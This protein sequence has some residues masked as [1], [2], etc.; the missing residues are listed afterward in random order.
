MW[1]KKRYLLR[2]RTGQ[3]TAVLARDGTRLAIQ[4]D[5]GPLHEVDAVLANRGRALSLRIGERMHLIH[6]S[7][8]DGPGGVT[9]TLQGRPVELT[10]L[11]ELRALAL[12]AEG[13]G[14]GG[15]VSTEIPGLVVSVLVREGQA[16]RAGQPVIVVEAMKMQNELAAA[17]TG[18]V[19]SVPVRAGQT[20]NPGDPLVI[21]E[22]QAAA[23]AQTAQPSTSQP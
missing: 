20:V 10:V 15:T 4:I 16:V 11:D 7:A 17:I 8:S 12:E 5:D 1:V 19:R 23:A 3:H 18:V 6:L 22:P 13:P 9:A 2:N 14:G 21:I